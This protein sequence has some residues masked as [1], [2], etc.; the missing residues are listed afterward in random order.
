MDKYVKL[1]KEDIKDSISYFGNRFK[2]KRELWVLKEFLKYLPINIDESLIKGSGA[3]P[4]DV[5]YN[6]IGFQVKEIQTKGRKRHSEYK[7]RFNLITEK[8]DLEDLLEPYHHIHVPISDTLPRIQAELERHRNKKYGG[9]VKNINV[10]VYLNLSDTT[11]TTESLDALPISG[12]LNN[13]L[14]V[15]VVTNNC[16]TILSCRDNNNELLK[17]LV[18]PIYFPGR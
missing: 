12:E 2:K 9:I 16:A 4:N 3:E 8:T 10:L 5:F 17:T 14:S 18:G 6:G 11:Y 1:I 7:N 15:S 13:W